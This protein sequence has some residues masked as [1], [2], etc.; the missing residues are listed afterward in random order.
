MSD[1]LQPHRLQH[2]KLQGPPLSS[3]VCLNSCPLSWGHELTISSS[4]IPFSFF[5]KSF[6]ASASFPMSQFL[7]SGGQSS[8]GASGSVFPK[9][10]QSSFPLGLTSLIT[11]QSK[12]LSRVF[13][14]TTV[15]THQFFGAQP[16][17]RSSSHIYT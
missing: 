4:A 11:W 17:L 2:T 6:P 9:N 1:S 10:F 15:Q 5:L 14:N 13:S 16:S 7:A 3:G 8:F 12:G